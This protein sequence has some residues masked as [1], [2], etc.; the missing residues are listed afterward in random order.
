MGSSNGLQGRKAAKPGA[1]LLVTMLQALLM[2]HHLVRLLLNLLLP[3]CIPAADD[4][5]AQV[6]RTAGCFCV[7]QDNLQPPEI[8]SWPKKGEN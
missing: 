4:H 5:T 1:Y 6:S 8:V 7:F 2:V 3:L